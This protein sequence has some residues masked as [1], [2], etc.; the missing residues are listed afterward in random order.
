M[1]DKNSLVVDDLPAEN[2]K[3][4]FYKIEEYIQNTPA[5]LVTEVMERHKGWSIELTYEE[6]IPLVSISAIQEYVAE[7]LSVK[8]MAFME[9]MSAHNRRKTCGQSW[10]GL[11]LIFLLMIFGGHT[12]IKYRRRLPTRFWIGQSG[13]GGYRAILFTREP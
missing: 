1:D 2:V 7:E 5:E 6:A 12:G 8:N 3:F 9:P 10:H 11:L 4:I 13:Y